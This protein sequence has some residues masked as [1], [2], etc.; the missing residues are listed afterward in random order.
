MI[1]QKAMKYFLHAE[2]SEKLDITIELFA[3]QYLNFYTG[4]RDFERQHPDKVLFISY[5]EM[6]ENTSALVQKV[7]EWCR[8][9]ISEDELTRILELEN[10]PLNFNKGITGRGANSLSTNQKSRIAELARY[11]ALEDETYLGITK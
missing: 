10:K 6:K 3:G 11:F 4:W 5:E 9:V 2:G 1:N 8:C 7:A